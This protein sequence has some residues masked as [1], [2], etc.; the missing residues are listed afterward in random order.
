M[1]L[2]EQINKIGAQIAKIEN[3]CAEKVRFLEQQIHELSKRACSSCHGEGTQYRT[4]NEVDFIIDRC[5]ACNG[6]GFEND[7]LEMKEGEF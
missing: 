4:L 2:K 6:T 7:C 1:T 5:A 3:D